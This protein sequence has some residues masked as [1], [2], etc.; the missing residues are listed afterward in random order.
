MNLGEQQAIYDV[1]PVEAV[2]DVAEQ[3][4]PESTPAEVAAR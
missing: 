4:E 3:T 2:P 1:E